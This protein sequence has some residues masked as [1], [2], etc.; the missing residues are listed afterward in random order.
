MTLYK[1]NNRNYVAL[2]STTFSLAVVS[3]TLFMAD[4]S[5]FESIRI[6]LVIGIQVLTGGLIWSIIDKTRAQSVPNF[7][8]LGVAI[9]S[10]ISLLA[11]QLLRQSFVGRIGWICPSFIVLFYM[12]AQKKFGDKSIIEVTTVCRVTPE[13]KLFVACCVSGLTLA[14]C[15]WWFWLLPLA[16]GTLLV[17]VIAVIEKR[18]GFLFVKTRKYR[19]LLSFGFVSMCIFISNYLEGKFKVSYVYSHD[20]V[21]SESLSWSLAKFGSNESP[22]E[23]GSAIRYHWFSLGWAGVV[24]NAADATSWTV[25]TK[26]LPILSFLAII[27]LIWSILEELS[28]SLSTRIFGVF[29]AVLVRGLSEFTTPIRYF[30]SP[31]FLFGSVWMLAAILVALRLQKKFTVSMLFLFLLLIFGTFGGKVTNGI[32]LVVGLLVS[33]SL[34]V[35]FNKSINARLKILSLMLSV[36][37]AT[38]IAYVVVFMQRDLTSNAYGNEIYIRVGEIGV[39]AG[40]V[41]NLSGQLT[42]IFG[43]IVYLLD[44]PFLLFPICILWLGKNR[45]RIELW[46]LT[47]IT[48]SGVVA[49]MVLGQPGASQMYFLMGSL[50]VSP[51]AVAWCVD[52]GLNLTRPT[53][54]NKGLLILAAVLAAVL[55]NLFW[56]ASLEQSLRSRE[57]LLLKSYAVIV[58]LIVGIVAAFLLKIFRSRNKSAFGFRL[59]HAFILF[60]VLLTSIYGLEARITRAQDNYDPKQTHVGDDQNL[61]TGSRDHQEI[62]NWVRTNTDETDVLATNRFCIPGVSPCIS[63]WQ[64]VS[65]VSHRRMFIEGGYW[66]GASADMATK[67]KVDACIRFA[68]NPTFVDWSFLI[69]NG[70]DYFF[71]DHA[72]S[73]HLPDWKPYATE[74]LSNKSVTLLRLNV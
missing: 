38:C 73:P 67:R 15:Y 64:L 13:T 63:K 48:I 53:S 17:F 51:I 55:G 28:L 47:G 10:G 37:L 3:M 22:F 35:I 43:S 68:A 34:M 69:A 45:N 26:L 46:L 52:G 31:T 44:M 18:T 16:L 4:T 23:A 50:I 30:H 65:A 42:W 29:V 36:A 25:I 70:V 6:G 12:C 21:F 56:S 14:L 20:Q 54:I 40:F 5:M 57:S 33:L 2:L 41:N 19:I 66:I 27:G 59:S 11:Q 32:I 9:G 39:D 62:L 74:I 61:V 1:M 72:V 71:V 24:T 8:G 7:L 49:T 60:L 58:P